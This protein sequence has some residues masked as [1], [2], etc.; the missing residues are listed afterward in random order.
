M[1][2]S[3]LEP[4]YVEEE[5]SQRNPVSVQR[6]AVKPFK[7]SDGTYVP[8]GNLISV[9]QCAVMRDSKNYEHAT[10]F[11]GFRFV[12]IV[13]GEPK[14]LPKYTDVTWSYPFWGA[15]RKAWLV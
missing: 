10:S 2:V 6:K 11:D 14:S 5:C 4:L 13:D 12:R 1:R 8:A 9:P 3:T 15:P 7:F